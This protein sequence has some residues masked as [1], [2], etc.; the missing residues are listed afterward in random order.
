MVLPPRPVRRLLSPVVVAVELVLLA[1][2]AV[3]TL[4]GLLLV[5]VSRH[6]RRRLLRTAAFG[7]GY[8][9]IDVAAVAAAAGLWLAQPLAGRRGGDQRWDDRH[10]RLLAWALGTILGWARWCFGFVVVLEERGPTALDGA[11]PVLALARHGGPGDS[12]ALVHLLLSHW[13]RPVRIVLKQVLQLDPALDV[14]LNRTGACWLPSHPRPGQDL[15][16]QLAE[17]AAGLTGR[18]VLLIFPEGGNWTP[19]RRRRAIRRLQAEQRRE[20]A[21]AATLMAHVLPPRPAGVLAVLG[22]RPDLPVVLLAHAGLDRLASVQDAWTALPLDVP[23]VVRPWPAA[24]LPADPAD[25]ARLGWL[26]TEWATVDEWVD[27]HRART[28]R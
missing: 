10:R 16:A 15:P 13:D 24:P 4:V 23:M 22:R 8:L 12:F 6:R 2:M 17:L 20:A 21:R 11:G 25:D 5:P 7:A 26:T 28:V 19:R 14:L 3:A 9:C 18:E 1:L 27:A